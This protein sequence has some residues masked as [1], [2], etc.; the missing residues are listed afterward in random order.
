MHDQAGSRIR[1]SCEDRQICFDQGKFDW[2]IV[3][4]S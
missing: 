2:K 3:L 1:A 4:M